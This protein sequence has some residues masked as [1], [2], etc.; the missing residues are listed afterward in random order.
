MNIL[1]VQKHVEFLVVFQLN[2]LYNVE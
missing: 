2:S 1:R